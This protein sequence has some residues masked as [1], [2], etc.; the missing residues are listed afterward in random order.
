MLVKTKKSNDCQIISKV[1]E[2]KSRYELHKPVEIAS[3]FN[4]YFSNIKEVEKVSQN[5]AEILVNR[6]F[7]DLSVENS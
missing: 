1:F 5:E 6:R 4:D 2:S 3:T 7:L